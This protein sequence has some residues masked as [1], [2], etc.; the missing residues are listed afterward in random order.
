LGFAYDVFKNGK[1]VIR[2]NWGIFFDRIVGATSG[3]VDGNTPGFAQATQTFPNGAGGTIRTV[4]NLATGDFAAK[5]AAPLTSLPLNQNTSIIVF[6][7]NL[8]T[9]YLQQINFGVSQQ[10][11]K[12]T[13]LE[14]GFVRTAGTKLFTW[15]DINQP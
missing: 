6:D 12:S 13:V 1:T 15:Q 9:G 14:M 3:S 4:S 2:G 8:R 5:P 7:Q 11:A 10:V